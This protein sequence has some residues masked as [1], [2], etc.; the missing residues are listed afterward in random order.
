MI[1]NILQIFSSDRTVQM[2]ALVAGILFVWTVVMI[3]AHISAKR[4][5]KKHLRE[6]AEYVL[7]QITQTPHSDAQ[8]SEMEQVRLFEDLLHS[9]I[10][11]KKPIIFEIAVTN[12][13]SDIQFFIASPSAYVETVKTQV[14]RVFERAQAQEVSDY[15]IFH[16]GDPSALSTMVLKDFYGLPIRSYQKIETDSFAPILAAFANAKEKRSGM[17]MQLVLQK[18]TKKQ[19]SEIKGVLK[20]LKGGKS[21][22]QLKPSKT[23][24]K[25]DKLV[26]DIA[27]GGGD[28]KDDEPSSET[29][30]VEEK[31][32]EQL[33]QVSARVGISAQTQEK[34]DLLLD[35]FKGRFDQFGSAG[36]NSFVFPKKKDKR[37]VIDFVFRLLDEKTAIVLSAQEISSIFHLLNQS[38]E[39]SNLQWMKTKRVAVP[40]EVAKE[41][42]LLGDNIF[43]GQETMV[44]MPEQ[45][46]MRHLYVIGQTGTGK[47]AIIKSMAYQDIQNG[48]GMCIIDPHGDLVD[49]M[50]AVVPE[51]RVDDVIVFDPS[52][53]EYPL[54][55]NM[56]EYDRS[57][58]QEKTFI[59]NEILSIFYSLFDAETM[60]PVFEQYMRN[61]LLLL[62]EGK[63]DEPATLMEVPTVLTDEDFRAELLKNC[64]NEPVNNFWKEEAQKAGGD[65]ALENIAPYITSKFSNFISND[66]VRP[67]IS[68]PYSSFS[69]RDAM[70]SGKLLFVRLPKGK[71]GEINARLLG[72]IVSGKLALAAFSRDDVAEDDRRE[73]FFYIDEFQ[74]FTSDSIEQILSEARKY[75]LSL[76]IA[77]QY[78]AQLTDSIRGAVLGNVGTTISFRVGV[79][80]AEVLEKKFTP[81]FSAIELTEIENLNCVVGM[82]SNSKPLSPFTMKIRFSPRGSKEVKDKI[83]QYSAI[84]HSTGN[85][86][87]QPDAGEEKGGAEEA[88]RADAGEASPQRPAEQDAAG[89]AAIPPRSAGDADGM[90]LAPPP[91][92]PR[93]DTTAS[94]APR[95]PR[96]DIDMPSSPRRPA[97]DDAASSLPHPSLKN[98]V[99]RPAR[100]DTAAPPP[101][102][103][104]R[105]T[106]DDTDMSP[107]PPRPA[108]DVAPRPARRDREEGD[109]AVPRPAPRTTESD[110]TVPRP[111]FS[112]PPR[113]AAPPPRRTSEDDTVTP[114]PSSRAVRGGDDA[115]TARRPA[116]RF[117]RGGTG[118]D[119]ARPSRRTAG[120]DAYPSRRPAR[121]DIARAARDDA[122]GRDVVRP[123]RPRSAQYAKDGDGDAARRR[124]AR[125]ARSGGS[126]R[127]PL[128]RPAR[129]D[130]ASSL[131]HP[132]LKNSVPRPARDDTAVPPPP[133]PRRTAGDGPDMSPS[134]PRPPRGGAGVPPRRL[135]RDDIPA[136]RPASTTAAVRSGE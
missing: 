77:H 48:K 16:S 41:G 123:P 113:G 59:V 2:Y 55:L 120:D 135:P 5:R 14:R 89:V 115:D 124:P 91:R 95:P 122:D 26:S 104:R 20:G 88:E 57:R 106:R 98:S 73:F 19:I 128:P 63:I 10:P 130:A 97:R 131:P 9:I 23:S 38:V 53:I 22:K 68:Q 93:D 71:I 114:R 40:T 18:A 72:M 49:D 136:A 75:R 39:V 74:N 118:K 8:M 24:E 61:S 119:D 47:T 79:E 36:H 42:L 46:R 126:T 7:L 85:P 52:N 11:E 99:P 12:E 110:D 3:I 84:K 101:P 94:P 116:P 103:P 54:A 1:E 82:L 44:Y 121:D 34:V 65:A 129:D 87:N 17:A 112:R 15:T 70:D 51:K 105:P 64:H 132:S 6:S 80:D 66:Y 60:G 35:N 69:F 27:K 50:L 90:P 32:Q 92:P 29:G 111:A 43:H 56:L 13:G 67:I 108:R 58:P 100:D 96:D 78:M 86:G 127:A 28:K 102:P 45:D 117:S 30:L 37:E 107:S 25:V 81:Q 31:M 4:K 83:I 76:T 134:P 21:L 125:D 62:M 33:Y 109:G 133:P